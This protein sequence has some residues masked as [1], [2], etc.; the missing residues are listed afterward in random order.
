M[1]L[2]P[3]F[4]VKIGDRTVV[5]HPMLQEFCTKRYPK[6]Q[7]HVDTNCPPTTYYYVGRKYMVKCE[8]QHAS[9]V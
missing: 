3:K 2:R 8:V 1:N 9:D 4:A 7:V 6:K 5:C